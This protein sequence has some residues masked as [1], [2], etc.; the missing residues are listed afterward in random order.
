[1]F[2]LGR[3]KL[4]VLD[5][6][7]SCFTVY[8]M[9][10]LCFF[11]KSSKRLFNSVSVFKNIPISVCKWMVG[12]MD[13]HISTSSD[14]S[15]TVPSCG[16]FANKKFTSPLIVAFLRTS[17]SFVC[18]GWG[19]LERFITNFAKKCCFA[20]SEI[21][22]T[23]SNVILDATSFGASFCFF[24]LVGLKGFFTVNANGFFGVFHKNII[25]KSTRNS[26]TSG[27]FL[28]LG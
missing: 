19:Y 6:V 25:P 20:A 5:S 10:N 15:T 18:I 26:S 27:G 28:C 23:I 4:K 17:N 22:S 24:I 1:M 2:F 7:I 9:N 21:C 16:F 13:K 14:N 12:N 11:K 8:V 3:K